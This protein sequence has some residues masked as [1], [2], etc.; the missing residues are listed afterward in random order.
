MPGCMVVVQPS[1][2]EAQPSLAVQLLS[3]E[4]Q[5]LLAGAGP[6][7]GRGEPSSAGVG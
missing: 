5:T 2:V 4:A 7:F 1:Q 6:S 3:T